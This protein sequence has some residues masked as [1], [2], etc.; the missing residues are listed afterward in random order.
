MSHIETERKYIVQKPDADVLCRFD[1]YTESDIIQIYLDDAEKTHRIRRREYTGGKV[2]YTENTKLRISGMSSVEEERTI[3]AEE[4]YRLTRNIESGASP[5]HKVRRT[6]RY[7]GL[8]FEF[9]YYDKWEHS[10]IMEVELPSEAEEIKM[11]PFVR[12]LRDVTGIKPYS[13][14]SMAHSFP[15]EIV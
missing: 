6:V 15:K 3:S 4:Y 9:D 13:N 12:V 1:D 11:P 7:C 10:C 14:H 8:I 2:E 5:L